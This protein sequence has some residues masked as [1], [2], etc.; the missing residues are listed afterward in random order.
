[1][2][3]I[4]LCLIL[5]PFLGKAQNIVSNTETEVIN[6]VKKLFDGMRASDTVAVKSVFHKDARLQTSFINRKT[7]KPSL[8]SG[9]LE[10][11]V[12]ALGS[13]HPEIWDEKIWSYRTQIDDNLASVW[14]EYTF[15]LGDKMSHCGVNAFQLVNTIDGWKILQL[16]DTRR[17]ENC[18][19]NESDY[20]DQFVRDWH[21]AATV[22]DE[23]SFF[24]SMAEDGIY[25]GTD[26]SER[27]LR[28]EL[29]KWSEKA[30][31][32]DSAWDFKTKE[33][34]IHLSTN[35]EVAWWNETLDTWMGVCRGSGILE[36]TEQ[37]W[38]IKQY[39]LSVTVPND[40]IEDFKKLVEEN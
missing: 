3:I 31:Q 16:T 17:W 33:R 22:A 37:G 36:K 40:K 28:D 8:S 26:A 7:Q 35:G 18:I 19:T 38:K 4:V 34:Q 6:V 12:K 25:I 32:R 39:H 5:F 27:W 15:Y 11:F 1:M 10:N 29:R 14:T 2:R 24:G 23:E 13:P 30:F 9:T 20:L 21:H